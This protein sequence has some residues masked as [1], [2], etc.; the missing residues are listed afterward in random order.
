MNIEVCGRY[1]KNKISRCD[2]FP[3]RFKGEKG[4]LST[5]P[6]ETVMSR[7]KV[8]CFIIVVIVLLERVEEVG[9]WISLLEEC[10]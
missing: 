3:Y 1:Y 8:C 7:G 6:T 10:F 5:L 9:S 4:C 2:F